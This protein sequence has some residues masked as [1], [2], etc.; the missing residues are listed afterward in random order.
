MPTFADSRSY[1]K[2]GDG[3]K[4]LKNY[5]A[6]IKLLQKAVNWALKGVEGYVKIKEDGKYGR[7]TE[8]A[9]IFFQTHFKFP[10]KNGKW[11]KKCN[12]KMKEIKR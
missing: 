4:T 3:Y 9:V 11:G 6:Q 12:K 5:K 10:D 7:D 1:Y 8:Q 2:V